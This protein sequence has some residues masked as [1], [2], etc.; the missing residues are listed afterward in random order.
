[1]SRRWRRRR[2]C[3]P[4]AR[5][6]VT[7][8]LTLDAAPCAWAWGGRW[9]R[10]RARR[11]DGLRA[12]VANLSAS[13]AAAAEIEALWEEYEKAASPEALL[14]KDLDKFEMIVQAL[15]YERCTCVH[16]AR[17]AP[18]RAAR[19]P[20]V[21]HRRALGGTARTHSRRQAARRLLPL[22]RR[23][24]CAP[25]GP[26]VGRGLVRATPRAAR[27]VGLDARPRRVAS[28]TVT[29]RPADRVSMAVR[30]YRASVFVHAG[31]C[32]RR[33]KAGGGTRV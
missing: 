27:A 12:M 9:L 2:P 28:A 4:R 20:V 14:V 5:A 11:Q 7:R 24:V 10:G 1:M 26:R 16:A 19:S 6:C 25:T 23:K 21:A 18:A 33:A 22:D 8:R 32:A 3:P 15:E 31:Q 17:V 29:R 13:P 30:L